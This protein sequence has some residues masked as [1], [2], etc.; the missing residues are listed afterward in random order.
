MKKSRMIGS[1]IFCILGFDIVML[2]TGFVRELITYGTI[3]NKI[4]DMNLLVS[5]A[6]KPFGGFIF[7]GLF[8][9]LYRKIRS[10]FVHPERSAV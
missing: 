10:L 2:I 1:L 7:L 5:G 6:G 8:C 9:G 4:V 3:N